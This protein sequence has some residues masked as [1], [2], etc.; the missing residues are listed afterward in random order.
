[1]ADAD[2]GRFALTADELRKT[3]WDVN[4]YHYDRTFT[5]E[6]K[7][8]MEE[9]FTAIKTAGAWYDKSDIMVDYFDTAFYIDVQLGSWA[10]GPYTV[11]NI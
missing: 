6:S 2:M 1:V 4:P 10:K 9:L 3:A 7:E 8:F 11:V 5:G